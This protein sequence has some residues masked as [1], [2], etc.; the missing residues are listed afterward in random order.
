MW[1]ILGESLAIL[2]QV[3][4]LGGVRH[5]NDGISKTSCVLPLTSQIVQ[6][7]EGGEVVI[8]C[9]LPSSS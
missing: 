4:A 7:L 3:C 2:T 9:A 5:L 8:V 6:L 1:H